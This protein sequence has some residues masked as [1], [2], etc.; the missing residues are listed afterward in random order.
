LRFQ[1]TTAT[2]A[3]L[4]GLLEVVAQLNFSLLNQ[5]L[6]GVMEQVPGA[7]VQALDWFRLW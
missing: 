1:G 2:T 4:G 6:T 7:S 5:W 3:P